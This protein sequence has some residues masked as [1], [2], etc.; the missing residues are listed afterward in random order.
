VFQSGNNAAIARSGG[1]NHTIGNTIADIV[2]FIPGVTASLVVF[3][4]F[5]TTKSWRQYRD[6]ITGGCGQKMTL[7]EKQLKHAGGDNTNRL[8]FERLPSLLD[9]PPLE[10]TIKG[11]ELESRV[12]M[13]SPVSAKKSNAQKE[14]F[15]RHAAEVRTA[16]AANIG[17]GTQQFHKPLR[18]K[19]LAFPQSQIVDETI[20]FSASDHINDPVIQYD[21]RNDRTRGGQEEKTVVEPT[22]IDS[23]NMPK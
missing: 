23:K 11:K 19:E 9:R 21:S 2:F 7:Q 6:L 1:P 3:I 5:G 22:N 17:L 13:F 18:A 10:I 8:E 15:S 4:V 12:R 14:A 16:R 20:R